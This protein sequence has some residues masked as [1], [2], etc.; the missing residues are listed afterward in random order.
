MASIDSIKKIYNHHNTVLFFQAYG[1]L[2]PSLAARG[3]LP[4]VKESQPGGKVPGL[5][6]NNQ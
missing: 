6:K 2:S 1:L 3:Q 4:V 5:L